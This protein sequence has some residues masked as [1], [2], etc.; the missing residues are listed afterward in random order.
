MIQ[1]GDKI[2]SRELFDNHFICHLE[3]CKGNCCIFGDSGAPLEDIE[4]ELIK[5]HLDDIKPFM[6]QR[7]SGLSM[8]RVVG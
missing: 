6:R 4:A 7:E 1:I 3:K 8:I 2:I 5:N